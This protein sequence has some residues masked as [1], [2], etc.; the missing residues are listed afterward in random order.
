MGRAEEHELVLLVVLVLVAKS[1]WAFNWAEPLSVVGARPPTLGPGN[2][3]YACAPNGTAFAFDAGSGHVYWTASLQG[4]VQP[5]THARTR[6]RYAP[7]KWC[8]CRPVFER[9]PA[10]PGRCL[11]PHWD[12][13]SVVNPV[14]PE[15][16]LRQGPVEV[17]SSAV[18][19]VT[20]PRLSGVRDCCVRTDGVVNRSGCAR[21]IMM[22]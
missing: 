11:R 3:G 12:L 5:R 7:L 15:Q 18:P 10:G 4:A 1:A 22:T 21:T 17:V 20:L 14:C 9:L 19:H 8:C 16:N 13:P 2:V 6:A